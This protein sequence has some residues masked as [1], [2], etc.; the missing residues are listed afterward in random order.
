MWLGAG[1]GYGNGKETTLNGVPSNNR[2]E[3]LGW[4]FSVGLPVTRCWSL[5]FKYVGL[6][7]Q[8]FIGSDT[9]NFLFSSTVL[10]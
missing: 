5:K 2:E 1:L 8:R 7:K 10:W 6:R 3:I 4:E 9:D